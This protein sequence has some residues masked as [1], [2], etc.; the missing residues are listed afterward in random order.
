MEIEKLIE[1][2]Q[3]LENKEKIK[4]EKNVKAVM[5]YQSNKIKE[6]DLEFINYKLKKS[7]EY[8]Y[9][10]KETI[11]KKNKEHYHKNNKEYYQVNKENII[12]YNKENYHKKKE[13]NNIPTNE[14]IPILENNQ[15]DNIKEYIICFD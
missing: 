9:K 8:Y 15:E 5:K 11:N 1:K 6:N 13:I 7:S 12:K 3:L 14:I 2:I 4:K 10:N